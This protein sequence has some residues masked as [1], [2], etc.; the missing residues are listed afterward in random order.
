MT[1]RPLDMILQE[2]GWW[3]FNPYEAP[4]EANHPH[5]FTQRNLLRNA[6]M[7]AGLHGVVT[8][9]WIGKYSFL[10]DTFLLTIHYCLGFLILLWLLWNCQKHRVFYDLLFWLISFI[11]FHSA[12]YCLNPGLRT[13]NLPVMFGVMALLPC[14]L[15]EAQFVFVDWLRLRFSKRV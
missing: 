1:E 5:E 10:S 3:M 4:A 9:T 13:S 15:S 14:C 6:V 12:N 11:C 7:F 8:A 2:E